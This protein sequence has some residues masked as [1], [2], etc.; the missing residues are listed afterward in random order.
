M[1][2]VCYSHENTKLLF[3]RPH[4]HPHQHQHQRHNPHHL[5]DC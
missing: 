2:M 3:F 5:I 4:P 1:R